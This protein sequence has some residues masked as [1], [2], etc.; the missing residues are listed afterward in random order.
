MKSNLE[1]VVD[2]LFEKWLTDKELKKFEKKMIN[3][4]MWGVP[5]GS[6]HY[7]VKFLKPLNQIDRE[8]L[9]KFLNKYKKDFKTG[10]QFLNTNLEG[11][12]L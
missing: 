8:I 10:E 4:I 1:H 2:D 5:N 7:H 3:H 9:Q 11:F 12:I 6:S